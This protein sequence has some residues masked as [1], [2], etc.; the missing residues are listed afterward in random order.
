[1]REALRLRCKR[2]DV[3]LMIGLPGQ[4]LES[5]CGTVDYCEHLFQVGDRRLSCYISPMGPF[6]DPG[7]RGFEE[8]E[9]FDY[10]L[11]ARTL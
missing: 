1:M 8:A 2:L 7:S 10:R 5:V 4:T 3:F 6:L 9:R 11:S